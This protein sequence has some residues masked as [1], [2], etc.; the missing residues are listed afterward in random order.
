MTL[1]QGISGHLFIFSQA[2]WT[3]VISILPLML[4]GAFIWCVLGDVE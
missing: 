3:G 4:K 1:V 2:D